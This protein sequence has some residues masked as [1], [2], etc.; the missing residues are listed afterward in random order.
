MSSNLIHFGYIVEHLKLNHVVLFTILYKQ[1]FVYCRLNLL[2]PNVH[3]KMDCINI[4]FIFL[5]VL[6]CYLLLSA[7]LAIIQKE[8]YEVE[9]ITNETPSPDIT[10]NYSPAPTLQLINYSVFNM[11]YWKLTY[12]SKLIHLY[13]CLYLLKILNYDIKFNIQ[14]VN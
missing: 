6:L 4:L 13:I 7:N 12:Y 5:Y 1:L 8:V 11:I 10:I 3:L 2:D 9:V 14:K